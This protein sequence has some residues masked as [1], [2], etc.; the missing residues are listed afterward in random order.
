MYG[1]K[2][3]YHLHTIYIFIRKAILFMNGTYKACLDFSKL[4]NLI[5]KEENLLK[6]KFIKIIRY[7][8]SKIMEILLH[9]YQII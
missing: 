1:L 7:F 8:M 5:E 3:M 6:F 9:I 4:L 2:M